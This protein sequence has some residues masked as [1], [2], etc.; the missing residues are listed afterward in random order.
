ME[1]GLALGGEPTIQYADDVLQNHMPE[2]Y[3][4]LFNQCLLNKLNKNKKIKSFFFNVSYTIFS[5]Y[6]QIFD[7]VESIWESSFHPIVSHVCFAPQC[8]GAH[9][10]TAAEM[11]CFLLLRT[12]GVLAASTA[13]GRLACVSQP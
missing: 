4:M 7:P 9:G 8:P 13:M 1:R 6:I 5:C 11:L 3:I 10:G 2:T 12:Q